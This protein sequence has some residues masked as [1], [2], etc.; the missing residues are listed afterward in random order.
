MNEKFH[1]ACFW[2]LLTG[3]NKIDLYTLLDL[4]QCISSAMAIHGIEHELQA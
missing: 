3:V 1:I 4:A 2:L